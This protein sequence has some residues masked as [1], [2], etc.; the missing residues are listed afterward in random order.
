MNLNTVVPAIPLLSPEGVT[1]NVAIPKI[2]DDFPRDIRQARESR[3]QKETA[4]LLR[5]MA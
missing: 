2:N 1:E 5:K 4:R 3:V